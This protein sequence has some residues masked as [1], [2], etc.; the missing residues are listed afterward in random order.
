[1]GRFALKLPK[2]RHF[3]PN[4]LGGNSTGEYLILHHL[5]IAGWSAA[6]DEKLVMDSDPSIEFG[7]GS[8]I[9]IAGLE[10]I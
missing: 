8:I 6:Y 10:V 2:L 4:R 3:A 9:E 1:L 7:L 5:D